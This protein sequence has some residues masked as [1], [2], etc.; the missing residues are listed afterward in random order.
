[1]K[2]IA[3]HNNTIEQLYRGA[4]FFEDFLSHQ[5]SSS[6][7]KTKTT[8]LSALPSNNF[9]IIINDAIPR[10]RSQ[11]SDVYSQRDV[12]SYTTLLITKRNG[13]LSSITNNLLIIIILTL[14]GEIPASFQ[15]FLSF[16]H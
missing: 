11:M 4:R 14:H 10:I 12:D 15:I 3:T 7:A 2:Y 13:E 1:M 16:R 8:D 5:I 6:I 9:I